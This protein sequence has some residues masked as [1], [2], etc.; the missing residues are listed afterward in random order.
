MKK[1]TLKLE[2]DACH[3][4]IEAL[5]ERLDLAV[6]W[7]E[8]LTCDRDRLVEVT[9]QRDE[10][11]KALQRIHTFAFDAPELKGFAQMALAKI[12]E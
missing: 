3:T 9:K 2:L 7:N 5:Q 1:A 6:A 11:A 12:G 4:T 10:L 8:Q